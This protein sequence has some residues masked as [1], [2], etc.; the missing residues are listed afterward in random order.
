MGDMLTPEQ[1]QKI[2]SIYVQKI[3]KLKLPLEKHCGKEDIDIEK[4]TKSFQE[5]RILY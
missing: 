2:C 3:L 1:R 5:N 4:I